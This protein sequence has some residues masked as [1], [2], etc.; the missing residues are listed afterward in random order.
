MLECLTH[1]WHP[2]CR[3]PDHQLQDRRQP[4]RQ[5]GDDHRAVTGHRRRHC[6]QS[7]P[8]QHE[9]WRGGGLL[10][11]DMLGK[12]VS[13]PAPMSLHTRRTSSREACHYKSGACLPSALLMRIDLVMGAESCPV[14]TMIMHCLC[15]RYGIFDSAYR[16]CRQMDT[17]KDGA[18]M[19]CVDTLVAGG[20]APVAKCSAHLLQVD[21]VMWARACGDNPSQLGL[22]LH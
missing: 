16:F 4:P 2:I 9:L 17:C 11:N 21:R 18:M 20:A 5:H 22:H 13:A 15:T 12:A 14:A 7:G 3:C 10:T 8:H 19:L 1:S 6:A